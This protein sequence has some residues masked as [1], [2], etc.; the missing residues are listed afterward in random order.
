M[1]TRV[2]LFQ[3]ISDRPLTPHPTRIS[4]W[5]E[6]GLSGSFFRLIARFISSLILQTWQQLAV[7][8]FGL[9]EIYQ[10]FG[11]TMM[12]VSGTLLCRGVL[13]YKVLYVFFMD[14]VIAN[15]KEDIHMSARVSD[16]VAHC[17]FLSSVTKS[18]E[19]ESDQITN[20]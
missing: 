4:P 9:S 20:E 8:S 13:P 6:H 7:S 15:L 12:A 2:D 14:W 11:S 16:L 19:R 17:R 5:Q 3:L 18:P 10:F 1:P